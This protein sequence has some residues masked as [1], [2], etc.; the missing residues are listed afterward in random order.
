MSASSR[1]SRGGEWSDPAPGQHVRSAG[2]P[3]QN[4]ATPDLLHMSPV[5]DE[6]S[7]PG[8]RSRLPYQRSPHLA[9]RTV[10]GIEA[11]VVQTATSCDRCCA[12]ACSSSFRIRTGEVGHIASR[13]SSASCH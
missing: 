4:G 2:I 3:C 1:S 9:D 11:H 12:L 6:L 8:S 13:A 5:P 7:A 10:P